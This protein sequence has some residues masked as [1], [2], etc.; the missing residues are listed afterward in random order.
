MEKGRRDFDDR[1]EIQVRKLYCVSRALPTLP[2]NLEDAARSEAEIEKAL[3]YLRQTLRLTYEEGVQMLKDAGVEIE[4]FGEEIISGAQRVHNAEM[5]ERRAKSCGID[6]KT[7]STYIDSFRYG[8]PTHGGFGVGLERVV[9]LF[10]GLNNIRKA[11]LY[12]RDPL[13]IAP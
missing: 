9:M 3:Q 6:V 5:L 1:H 4:P 13:R 12:P 8:A 7:I 10:C 2:I 11:S